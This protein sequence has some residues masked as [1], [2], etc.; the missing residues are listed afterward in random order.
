MRTVALGC[1]TIVNYEISAHYMTP[2][3][4]FRTRRGADMHSSLKSRTIDKYWAVNITALGLD[5]NRL[6]RN[7]DCYNS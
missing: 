3:T 2:L 5:P 6:A 4:G 1:L 7:L